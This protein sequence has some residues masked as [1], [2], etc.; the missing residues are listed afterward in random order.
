M[1][2]KEIDKVL[3]MAKDIIN[4]ELRYLRNNIGGGNCPFA[5]YPLQ[6]KLNI[7]CTTM[8]CR[9]CNAIWAKRR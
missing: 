1:T 3:E 6:T 7:D 5:V 8:D 9:N 4:L 2:R